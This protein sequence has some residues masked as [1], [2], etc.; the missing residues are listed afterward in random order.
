MRSQCDGLNSRSPPYS[1]PRT[2]VES[3]RCLVPA[4]SD[5]AKLTI[6]GKREVTRQKDTKPI[7]LHMRC[8]FPTVKHLLGDRAAADP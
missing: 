1:T 4:L 3:R 2:S 6:S 7:D 5:V 8:Q